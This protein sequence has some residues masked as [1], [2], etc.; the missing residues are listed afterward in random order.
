MVKSVVSVGLDVYDDKLRRK[1]ASLD[2][3]K[4]IS[5][6]LNKKVYA[7]CAGLVLRN[8]QIVNI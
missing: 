2:L 8:P 5:M 3:S 7:V 6:N 1:A 4:Q